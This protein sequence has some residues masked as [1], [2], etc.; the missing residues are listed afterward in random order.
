VFLV[1]VPGEMLA[2]IRHNQLKVLK[3]KKHS[4]THA[5]NIVKE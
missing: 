4:H 1:F 2:E 5:A 3:I